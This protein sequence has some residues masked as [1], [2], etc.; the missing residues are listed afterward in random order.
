MSAIPIVDLTHRHLM[1][2]SL[3]QKVRN[4]CVL[5]EILCKLLVWSPGVE[6]S[7]VTIGPHDRGSPMSHGDLKKYPHVPC[8]Y[9]RGR[10]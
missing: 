9:F 2:R 6:R 1:M 8:H 4:K 7:N 5:T 3:K 10:H